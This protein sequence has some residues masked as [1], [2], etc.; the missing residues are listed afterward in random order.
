VVVVAAG[1]SWA[2]AAR[3]VKARIEKNGIISFVIV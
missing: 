1:S 2:Q 3:N